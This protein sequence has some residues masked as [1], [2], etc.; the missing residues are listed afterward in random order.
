MTDALGQ[1]KT[2]TKP[3]ITVGSHAV[4][5]FITRSKTKKTPEKIEKQLERMYQASRE[6]RK[7]DATNS[8]INN[9]FKE[10]KYFVRNNWVLVVVDA[11]LV[12]CYEFKGSDFDI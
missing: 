6:A 4:E 9:G 11:V 2:P 12:T 7:K 1:E 10:A 5:R 8:L 3:P